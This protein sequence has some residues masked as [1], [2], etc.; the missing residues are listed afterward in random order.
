ME[1]ICKVSQCRFKFSHTTRGHKC[2]ICHNYGHGQLECGSIYMIE[3]LKKYWND[4]LDENERCSLSDC[5]DNC[6]HKTIAH[7]CNT[8]TSL[9]HSYQSCPNNNQK[10]TLNCPI[11]RTS[12]TIKIQQKRIRGLEETCCICMDKKVE[13]F[14]EECGHVCI[15]YDCFINI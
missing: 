14:L 8:C 3:E 9:G 1:N 11:C 4:T 6:Y 12:N 13:I 15:C 5:N 7:P 2:G 10:K